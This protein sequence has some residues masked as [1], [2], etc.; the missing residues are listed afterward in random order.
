[1][2]FDANGVPL[3]PVNING[4]ST[5]MWLD[6]G[7]AFSIVF[8]GALAPLGLKPYPIPS[9][10]ARAASLHLGNKQITQ[11]TIPRSL[12]LGSVETDGEQALVASKGP[13]V[14]DWYGAESFAD[15]NGV[16]PLEIGTNVLQQL[17][18]YF[19]VEQRMLYFTAADAH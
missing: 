10:S 13:I 2:R 19:A 12:R 14:R 18:L 4:H 15:C 3:V 9:Y 16:A 6:V 8:D 11:Y 7:S 5:K 1:M 17:R